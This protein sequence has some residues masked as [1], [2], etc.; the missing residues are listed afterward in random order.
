MVS[1]VRRRLRSAATIA[2]LREISRRTTP[3]AVFDYV[4]GSADGEV[5]A[6]E[7]VQ[8]F[9]AAR[10]VPQILHPVADP[11]LSTE[12]LGRRIGLPL[13]LAPT[14]FTRM[15][16]HEGEEAVARVAQRQHVP[17]ALSTLGTTDID[18]V[19]RAAPDGDNWFQLYMTNDRSLNRQLVERAERAGCTTLVL[20]TDCAVGGKRLRDIRGGLTIP[21]SLTMRTFL[22]MTR[23]PSW[24]ANK[25]TTP[26]VEFASVRDYPGTNMDV[27]RLLFDP[28]LSFEDF[29]WLREAWP[30]KLLVKGILNPAA[31]RR[32][33]DLGAD[34]VVV[35]NHGGRQLDRTPATLDVVPAVRHAV[36]ADAT[37]LVDGGIM[38]GQD[39]VAAIAAG[40]DA[41]MVGRAYLYGL[42]AAGERGVDRAVEILREEYQRALQ[43]MGLDGT[44]KISADS[45]TLRVPPV[46]TTANGAASLPTARL[47]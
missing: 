35:S 4:D 43:L 27:A 40:A 32:V 9:E 23:F 1:P 13:V 10:F 37:V 7:N 29:Q 22:G 45:V 3:R 11:D 5:T 42:M 44:S 28:G 34:G 18:D 21:P 17:Y 31:G 12:V 33:V 39:I 47:R 8:A 16:H 2:D 41:V 36:G 14:G 25:L 6:R 26:A 15:M 30:H 24:W 38:H 20:T 46:Q 19:L